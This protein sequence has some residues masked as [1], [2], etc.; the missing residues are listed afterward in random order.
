MTKSRAMS[1]ASRGSD[2]LE[3]GRRYSSRRR[4][5]REPRWLWVLVMLILIAIILFRSY[6]KLDFG[7][8][9]VRRRQL[10]RFNTTANYDH[11]IIVAGHG[12]TSSES[13]DA[14]GTDA[15][16][17]LLDYQ[18]NRDLPETFVAHIKRGVELAS[19]DPKSLLL[20][21]GGQTRSVAGPTSE[22]QSYFFI[23]DHFNWFGHNDVASR[24]ATEEYARDSFE[25]LKFSLCRFGELTGRYPL[26]RVTVV[27]F[28]FKRFRFQHVHA[29][30]LRLPSAQ[31]VYDAMSPFATNPKS[32]FDL[33]AATLGEANTVKPFQVDPYG[34][35]PP[36]QAKRHLRDPFR[37]TIPYGPNACPALKDLLTFCGPNLFNGSLPWWDPSSSSSSSG[38]TTPSLVEPPYQKVT[39]RSLLSRSSSSLLEEDDQ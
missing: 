37:R 7:A 6:S 38:K 5:H 20:F 19:K 17:Y 11:L 26:R 32:R 31:F 36:L 21:S 8:K 27:S 22:A 30:A 34:C 1:L 18:R 29:P 2:D 33:T 35:S 9:P 3:E 14:V 39:H 16:W 24:T 25:N 10:P 4:H 23:A 28:D 13:L 12:V 15:S